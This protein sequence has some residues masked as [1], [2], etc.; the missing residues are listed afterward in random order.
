MRTSIAKYFAYISL[1]LCLGMYQLHAQVRTEPRA[2]LRAMHGESGKL[3]FDKIDR[4]ALPADAEIDPDLQQEFL[5]QAQGTKDL[6]IVA[7]FLNYEPTG[8]DKGPGA[9]CG[10]F[11][12]Q[13]D[14]HARYISTIGP[15]FQQ[16]SNLCGGIR[17]VGLVSNLSPHPEIISIFN[18]TG[19]HGDRFPL[20][21]LFIW[22]VAENAYQLDGTASEW[23]QRQSNA[24][25]IT[26]VRRLLA[27]YR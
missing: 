3:L 19:M 10:V 20:P 24:S 11:F 1:T 9:Q 8:A 26:A 4:K 14:G 27:Q 6:G 16:G 21:F 17:A 13:P 22:S 18:G 2:S 12:L 5:L 7:T 23:L 15:D 25:T